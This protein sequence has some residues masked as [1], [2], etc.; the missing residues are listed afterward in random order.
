[1]SN[2]RVFKISKKESKFGCTNQ[3]T[4]RSGYVDTTP[5]LQIVLKT[6]Q[7]FLLNSSHKKI[8]AKFSYSKKSG[9]RKFQTLKNPSIIPVI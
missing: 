3:R 5:N 4:T 2:L 1:M 8:L 6:P 7:K 9:N